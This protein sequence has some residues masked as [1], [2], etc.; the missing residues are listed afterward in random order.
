MVVAETPAAGPAATGAGVLSAA[1]ESAPYA[2]STEEPGEGACKETEESVPRALLE[3]VITPLP[4]G[5]IDSF[6]GAFFVVTGDGR[7]VA[8]ALIEDIK[9]LGG[10]AV[11]LGDD[12]EKDLKEGADYFAD[13]TDPLA[14]EGVIEEIRRDHGGVAGL[15]HLRPM[16]AAAALRDTNMD[17]WRSRLKA[18]TKSL[19]YLAK[20]L[21]EDIRKAG[22]KGSAWLVTAASLTDKEGGALGRGGL[23]G[24]VKSV[25][26]EWPGVKCCAISIDAAGAAEG[27]KALSTRILNEVIATGVSDV[28]VSYRGGDRSVFIATAAPLRG[29]TGLGIAI[30]DDYVVMVTGGAVGITA[31]VALELAERYRPTLLLVGRSPLP[32]V[33]AQ[34]SS[35]LTDEREIKAALIKRLKARGG[36]VTPV[37]VG[38]AYERLLKD[39][40]IRANIEAMKGFGSEVRYFQASVSSEE[41][42]SEVIKE[43]YDTYGRLDGVI[44]GAGVIED[45]LVEDKTAE[46]F[47][48]VFDTKADSAFILSN[49]LR[50]ETLKFLVFFTSVAGSFGN[51][52]QAD[53][54]TANELVSGLALSLD[55]TLDARVVAMNWGPWKKKGMVTPEVERQFA[56]RGVQ[57]I[58]PSAGSRKL[59]EELRLGRK[60]EVGVVIGGGPWLK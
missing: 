40:E 58:P 11:L 20:A 24:F 53:Y 29:G 54:A 22:S 25:A 13:F 31:L 44:H 49:A 45:K 39:R 38:A 36:G 28:E 18:E 50:P 5:R 43:I 51:R 42:F 32:G 56:E 4:H 10:K 46:S 34:D 41:E 21:S 7:G 33:E 37:I 30:K 27:S 59:E 2:A 52:G 15:L 57:L 26:Q 16:A 47:D 3:P 48:R 60:G 35:G 17:E 6:E 55:R 23:A 12:R 9:G 19:F 8:R 1:E 14:I